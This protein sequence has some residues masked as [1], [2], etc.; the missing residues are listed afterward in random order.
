MATAG[1]T[2]NHDEIRGWAEQHQIVPVELFPHMV[3]HEPSSLRLLP[4]RAAK[5]RK[6]LLPLSWDDFFTRFDALGLTFVYDDDSTGANELLQIESKSAY[7]NPAYT[8][9]KMEH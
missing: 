8:P 3:D 6:D 5:E 1:P 7:R 2:T 4:R 9:V